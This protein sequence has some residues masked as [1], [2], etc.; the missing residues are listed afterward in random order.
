MRSPAGCGVLTGL[1]LRA[2]DFHILAGYVDI[3]VTKS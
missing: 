1:V 2:I 3:L